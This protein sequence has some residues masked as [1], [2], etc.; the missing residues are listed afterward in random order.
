VVT[1]CHALDCS[2]FV[3]QPSPP[4]TII[5]TGFGSFP[6]GLPFAGIS[7]YMSI[8]DTTQ[9]WTA[10]YTGTSCGVSISSWDDG[11][12]QLVGNLSQKP[13]CP[14]APGDNVVVTVW[15]PQSMAQAQATVTVVAP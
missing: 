6:N 5:G 10:G 14:L 1:E 11:E 15:N 4:I 8:N 13:A 2:R 9:N 3:A 12:I 7:N